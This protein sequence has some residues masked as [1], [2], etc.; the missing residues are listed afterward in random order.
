MLSLFEFHLKRLYVK[1]KIPYIWGRVSSWFLEIKELDIAKFLIFLSFIE[2]PFFDWA[3]L[4]F[5]LETRAIKR[6]RTIKN[7]S[8]WHFF[9]YKFYTDFINYL[10]KFY[11]LLC[12]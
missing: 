8:F 10:L 1:I 11:N 2:N 6:I 3:F 9:I 12:N 5:K 4:S 7:I